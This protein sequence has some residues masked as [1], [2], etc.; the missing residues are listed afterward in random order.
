MS[1]GC[2]RKHFAKRLR[3]LVKN[4][5][6]LTSPNKTFVPKSMVVH[7]S[8]SV[9]RLPANMSHGWVVALSSEVHGTVS[10]EQVNTRRYNTETTAW[11]RECH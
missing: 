7:T 10:K 1:C 4:G 9:A 2:G 3:C 6:T 8:T 5:L 11:A